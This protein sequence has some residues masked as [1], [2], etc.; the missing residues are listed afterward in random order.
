MIKIETEINGKTVEITTDHR[1]HG[2]YVQ[3]WEYDGREWA[4]LYA[5]LHPLETDF[6][7]VCSASGELWGE[8]VDVEKLFYVNDLPI[9][10]SD[11]VECD[12]CHRFGYYGEMFAVDSFTY[13]CEEC[14]PEP[15]NEP[16]ALTR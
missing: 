1:T 10:T 13:L 16:L 12:K 9:R 5:S 7:A 15:S 11:D 14:A 6:E 4:K 3:I 2:N 8:T